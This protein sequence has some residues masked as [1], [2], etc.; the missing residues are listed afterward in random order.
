MPDDTIDRSSPR[1]AFR[2]VPY[3]GVIFVVDEAHKRG[4]WNG[5]P[6]WSNLG[7]GQ[8]E[9]GMYEGAPP[10]FRLYELA[11]GEG[12]DRAAAEPEVLARFQGEL[13]RLN[14]PEVL[15][16]ADDTSLTMDP[17]DRDAL[18]QLG[19]VDADDEP[20][21]EPADDDSTENE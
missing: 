17:H 10:R 16:V 21:D 3:M 20:E 9:V 6:E 18:A 7:Q 5:H 19:Y 1:G 2:E 12:D 15:P 11:R 14:D 4:F 13:I 8:P